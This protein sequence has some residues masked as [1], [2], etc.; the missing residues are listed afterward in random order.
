M[1][2]KEPV[3]EN[4][5]KTPEQ[6]EQKLSEGKPGFNHESKEYWE[7]MS[8]VLKTTNADCVPVEC[9]G[10]NGFTEAA[11]YYLGDTNEDIQNKYLSLEG[12]PIGAIDHLSYNMEPAEGE[13]IVCDEGPQLTT[14]PKPELE[15]FVQ[16]FAKTIKE[17]KLKFILHLRP[18]K[19]N[20]EIIEQLKAAGL[21]VGETQEFGRREN[22]IKDIL[23]NE[24]KKRLELA[25]KNGEKIN[26]VG[27]E[28]DLLIDEIAKE[29][30]TVA[31]AMTIFKE[32]IRYSD[33]QIANHDIKDI[34][35]EHRENKGSS[36]SYL[37]AAVQRVDREMVRLVVKVGD[38][39]NE[40]E[41]CMY[42]DLSEE[43]KKL[44]SKALKFNF[45]QQDEFGFNVPSQRA[46]EVGK[47]VLKNWEK[48]HKE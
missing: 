21:K 4:S 40:G 11:Y 37:R 9:N 27:K 20:N 42:D 2:P 38:M 25:Q 13:I 28:K 34:I 12:N 46:Y 6:T 35:Y 15:K 10:G 23:K 22:D 44:V 26:F 1:D 33:D 17:K 3:E 5:G 41:N 36:L 48:D 19:K 43:E 16:E 32:V 14:L 7:E 31:E 18:T 47:K 45:L 24:L 8:R 29:S 39:R 30:I